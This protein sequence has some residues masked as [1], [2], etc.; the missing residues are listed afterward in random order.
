MQGDPHAPV[1]VGAGQIS[2]R[3]RELELSPL[4]LIAR[5]ARSAGEAPGA[6]RLL[7]R[8]ES[9]GVVD[10]LSWPVPDPGS[11][12]AEE[13]GLKPATTVRTLTSGTGPIEL[14][15]DACTRIQ[16]GQLD[17][18]LIAGAESIGPFMRA[19]GEGRMTGWP[20]QPVTAAPTRLLGEDRPAS[21][22]AEQAAGLL[23]PI[24]YYPWFENAVGAAAGRNPDRHREWVA[25]LWRRFAEVAASNPHAWSRD[26]P[27]VEEILTPG[28]DNRMIAFP[29]T[30]L[31]TANI[32][33]DQGAALLLCSARAAEDAGI[34][35]ERRVFVHATA[36][37]HDHWFASS[38][39]DLHRSP[40]IAACA[41]A[42]LARAGVG[43]D[44]IAH[45]DLYSCFPSAVQIA[46]TEL[47]IDL[48]TDA[49]PPTV[50]GGLSFGGGPGSNYVTHS[51]AAMSERLRED[52]GA[53]GLL[54]GV[55]WYM[56]KH[57]NAVL[58]TVPPTRPYSHA[59]PQ[60]EVDALPRRRVVSAADADAPA[61]SYTVI[62]DR[63][64]SPTQAT[65]SHLLAD[66]SRA[67]TGSS[68]EET[69]RE[70][71]DGIGPGARLS[72]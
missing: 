8:T 29:Y 15:A 34:E 71:L 32:Q 61:E 11:L 56:T 41:R 1:L 63:D 66:G 49:R 33:V 3:D 2:Q 36:A 26:A 22:E 13:L 72:T 45:L 53:Y 38:R 52:P 24:H 6:A 17:V 30:K 57:A 42:S 62:C 40:A 64:G 70:L 5:S 50:T 43:I 16:A 67:L 9:V 69:M 25:K 54:T 20:E 51:L 37:A 44:E 31:M 28:P 46:A 14:L 7:K 47:C 39:Q 19:S 59:E 60:A 58:S 27:S 23:A 68:D 21:N 48:A 4:E 12:V 18:A 10:C 65:V 55:G 35:P